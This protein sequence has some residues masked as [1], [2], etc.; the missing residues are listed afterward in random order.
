MHANE[1]GDYLLLNHPIVIKFTSWREL[2]EISV[3]KLPICA[4][5]FL[6]MTDFM[7]TEILSSNFSSLKLFP[8]MSGHCLSHVP[9]IFCVWHLCLYWDCLFFLLDKFGE[10]SPISFCASFLDNGSFH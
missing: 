3:E 10:K 4:Y 5:S 8:G 2:R 6:Y 7:L 9:R 1:H